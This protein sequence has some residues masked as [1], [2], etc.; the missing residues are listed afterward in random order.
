MVPPLVEE[1]HSDQ[2]SQKA[3]NLGRN[4]SNDLHNNCGVGVSESTCQTNNG[5]PLRGYQHRAYGASPL[6][7]YPLQA[8]P[9]QSTSSQIILPQACPQQCFP[10]NPGQGYLPQESPQ[11]PLPSWSSPSGYHPAPPAPS[12]YNGPTTTQGHALRFL[13]AD[14]S[15]PSTPKQVPSGAF[16]N[17]H[18]HPHLIP[19]HHVSQQEYQ[20]Y[21]HGTPTHTNSNQPFQ[22]DIL[23]NNHGPAQEDEFIATSHSLPRTCPDL[24]LNAPIDDMLN[25]HSMN[26]QQQEPHGEYLYS[27]STNDS[28]SNSIKAP[29]SEFPSFEPSGPSAPSYD[30]L[31]LPENNFDPTFD[32]RQYGQNQTEKQ[33]VTGRSYGK[34]QCGPACNCVRCTTHPMNPATMEW[35]QK[36]YDTMDED[37]DGDFDGEFD[38]GSALTSRPQASYGQPDWAGQD[39]EPQAQNLDLEVPPV[40]PM[41]FNGYSVLNFPIN[42]CSRNADCRCGDNCRCEGCL[43]HSGHVKL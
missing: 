4:P 27:P 15:L 38:G 35:V 20:S 12:H 6:Q 1:S 11:A 40:L 5:G 17:V 36:M 29:A 3:P 16:G 28:L 31:N 32:N 19:S 10:G 13:D 25:Q 24:N 2:G 14:P 7:A 22:H 21:P 8:P 18:G 41:D 37:F 23:Y 33:Q 26:D 30:F 43:T 9:P 34:C 39:L 42:G